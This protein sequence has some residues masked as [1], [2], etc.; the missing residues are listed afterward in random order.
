M[1]IEFAYGSGGARQCCKQTGGGPKM[2]M[3]LNTFV[4]PKKI[5]IA[6]FVLM[7]FAAMC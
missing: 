5:K 7:T 1:R 6:L 4:T 3:V 2:V